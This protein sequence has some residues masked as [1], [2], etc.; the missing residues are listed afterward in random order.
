MVIKKKRGRRIFQSTCV[1][2]YVRSQLD[3]DTEREDAC[4]TTDPIDGEY[5]LKSKE[6]G[7]DSDEKG[8][9]VNMAS[10]KGKEKVQNRKIVARVPEERGKMRSWDY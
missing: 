10:K 9:E 6:N 1:K 3:Q 2:A 4:G 7:D 5:V 8:L